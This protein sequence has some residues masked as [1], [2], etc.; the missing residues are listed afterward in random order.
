MGWFFLCL[1]ALAAL[2]PN[3]L[4]ICRQYSIRHTLKSKMKS[5]SFLI[6]LHPPSFTFQ[7]P[8]PPHPIFLFIKFPSDGKGVFGK[9]FRM[10][11]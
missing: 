5:F 4:L 2:A 6:S 9:A 11:E 10:M 1:S 3:L 8:P 7:T